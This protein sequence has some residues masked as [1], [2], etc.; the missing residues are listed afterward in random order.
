MEEIKNLIRNNSSKFAIRIDLFD[1]FEKDGRKSLAFRIV[2][3]NE[4]RTLTDE[5]VNIEADKI[6]NALKEKGFE[7]R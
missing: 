2:Y 3:Q 1:Q 7:I 6:Y 4:L 5:E